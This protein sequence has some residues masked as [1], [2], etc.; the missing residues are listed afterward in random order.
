MDIHRSSGGGRCATC[1]WPLR[2]P[3]ETVSRHQ[4]AE[5]TLVYSRCACGTLRAWLRR[6]EGVDRLVVGG[7]S[8]VHDGPE[9][10]E[11]GGLA[12]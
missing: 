8:T 2:D 12:D 3:Y 7:R 4:V 5:G 11:P 10:G 1:G 9:R 6:P